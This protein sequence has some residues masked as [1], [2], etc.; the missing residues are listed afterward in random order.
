MR[1]NETARVLV[2]DLLIMRPYPDHFCGFSIVENLVDEA[3]LQSIL[4]PGI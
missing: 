3:M 1:R 4:L 2:A